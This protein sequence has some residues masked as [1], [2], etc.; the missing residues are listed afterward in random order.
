VHG[1]TTARYLRERTLP[2]VD[3]GI[4]SSGRT[5]AEFEVTCPLFL[6]TG[7]TE[8]AMAKSRRSVCQQ[9]A[10]Y[11]STPAYRT[12]LELHGWGDLQTELN[13][14][15]KSDRPDKWR[16]MGDL[17]EDEVLAAF[18]VVGEPSTL[19]ERIADRFGDDVDRISL[20]NLSVGPMLLDRVR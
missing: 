13:V 14:L 10:F 2:A 3:K 20:L 1:F 16:E 18:A 5:R 11:G 9:I 4:A 8:E 19:P 15:S 17:I 7:L 12:V 6:V